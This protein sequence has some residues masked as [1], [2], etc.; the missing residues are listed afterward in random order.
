MIRRAIILC[1]CL[2]GAIAGCKD[3]PVAPPTTYTVPGEPSGHTAL[4]RLSP[5]CQ[6]KLDV[7]FILRRSGGRPADTVLRIANFSSVR[8][9]MAKQGATIYTLDAEKFEH[10]KGQRIGLRTIPIG[11]DTVDIGC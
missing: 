4:I 3:S 9:S 6:A 10:G 11:V 2:C 8:I 1:I 5:G 7:I